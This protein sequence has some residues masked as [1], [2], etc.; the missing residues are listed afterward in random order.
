VVAHPTPA[1]TIPCSLLLQ[2]LWCKIYL[3]IYSSMHAECALAQP[4]HNQEGAG[5]LQ[6]AYHPIASCAL[7]HDII[8]PGSLLLL[9]LHIALGLQAH[10]MNCSRSC[11]THHRIQLSCRELAVHWGSDWTPQGESRWGHIGPNL[12]MLHRHLFTPEYG[13]QVKESKDMQ[14]LLS[15]PTLA[16]ITQPALSPTWF[17]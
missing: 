6:G 8:A 2:S 3:S 12:V 15:E 13:T 1:V 7:P 14:T 16:S 10:G 4:L 9:L 5:R 17:A 11:I